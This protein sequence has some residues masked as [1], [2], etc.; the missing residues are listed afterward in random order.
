M[1]S[2]SKYSTGLV[3]P[4]NI[5]RLRAGNP[6]QQLPQSNPE[7][8]PSQSR[9]TVV[10]EIPLDAIVDSP[11]QPRIHMDPVALDEL[12][13]SMKKS[14][15]VDIPIRV[16]QQNGKWELIA[17]HR[18]VRAAQSLGWTLIH[19]EIV[20]WDDKEAN[21]SVL[22]SNIGRED[23]SD[24]ELALLF[25]HAKNQGFATTQSELAEMF[26]K[27]QTTVSQCLAMLKLPARIQDFLKLHPAALGRATAYELSKI[28]AEYPQHL[29]LVMQGL[30]RLISD[31]AQ[32]NHLGNWI[33]QQ[34]QAT[35]RKGKAKPS[36]RT[37]VV[38]GHPF[39]KL[40]HKP[41]D[42]EIVLKLDK[43]VDQQKLLEYLYQMLEKSA[44]EFTQA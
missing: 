35:S 7:A 20:N 8:L 32:Q 29:E 13:L 27:S 41:Q 4:S 34:I 22:L 17:G 16:R 36:D 31:E 19:A 33:K 24:F 25:E 40:K 1:A 18:R 2:K 44:G 5:A 15:R 39:A 26:A 23:L 9:E 14:G 10:R 43:G 28:I 30:Q 3:D 6:V 21:L 12:A 11:Y 38:N 37:V 42:N